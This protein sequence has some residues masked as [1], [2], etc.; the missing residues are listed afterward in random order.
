[1]VAE[2]ISGVS[3]NVLMQKYGYKTKKSI[4]DKVKKY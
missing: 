3:V 1:M 2:Y 4:T